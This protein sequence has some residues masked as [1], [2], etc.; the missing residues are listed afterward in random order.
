MCFAIGPVLQAAFTVIEA[1]LFG[2]IGSSV[3]LLDGGLAVRRS[4]GAA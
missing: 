3:E 2:S 4:T 1:V